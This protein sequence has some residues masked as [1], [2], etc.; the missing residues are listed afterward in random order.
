MLFGVTL[1]AT[2]QTGPGTGYTLQRFL[3]ERKEMTEV[4][5][6][7]GFKVLSIGQHYCSDDGMYPQPLETLAWLADTAKGMTLQT[8]ILLVPL[9]NPVVLAEEMATL[10]TISDGRFVMC[11]GIG[12]RD[13]EFNMLG[14]NL[15][16]RV[17]RTVESLEVIR[18]LFTNE[19]VN[20][21]GR[22]FK[23]KGLRMNLTSVQKPHPPIWYG[24][25]SEAG[26][27]RAAELFD[28]LYIGGYPPLSKL[29]PQ[30]KLYWKTFDELGKPGPKHLGLRR[31][32]Y[33]DKD[34]KTALAKA[35][36]GFQH[37]LGL[38]SQAGLESTLLP[39]ELVKAKAEAEPE[40]P[41]L[42]GNPEEV[43]EQIKQYQERLGVTHMVFRFQVAGLPWTQV[44]KNM[45]TFGAKVIPHF[46]QGDPRLGL[47]PKE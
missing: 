38:Y 7:T 33:F 25:G 37:T 42:M 22:H 21:E 5:R 30:V 43:V 17:S 2:G 16:H 3:R 19:E 20:H 9:Y 34:R 14:L 13:F 15:K 18:K 6:D 31:E 12:Y 47:F 45:E 23:I 4:A 39:P 26:T 40:L 46:K 41:F 27:R 24:T 8:G 35:L 1:L 29:E 11:V 32:I 28:G 36:P 44:L 10:D